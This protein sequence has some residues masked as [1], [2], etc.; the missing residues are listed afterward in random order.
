MYDVMSDCDRS[1]NG[2]L[3]RKVSVISATLIKNALYGRKQSKCSHVLSY[4]AAFP[5]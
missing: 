2:C 5:M 1:E 3:Q 4:R